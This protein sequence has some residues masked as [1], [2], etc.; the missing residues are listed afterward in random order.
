LLENILPHDLV[1]DDYVM[2]HNFP[3][4]GPQRM[5]LNAR[6]IVTALGNTELILLAIVAIDRVKS[7]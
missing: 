5:M 2:E 6:R 4:L 7:T 1:I 3:M